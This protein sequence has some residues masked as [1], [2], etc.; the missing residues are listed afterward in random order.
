M[1]SNSQHFIILGMVAHACDHSTCETEAGG[2]QVQPHPHLHK[3][4]EAS[5]SYMRSYLEKQK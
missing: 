4:F 2:S 1:G 5:L 3:E